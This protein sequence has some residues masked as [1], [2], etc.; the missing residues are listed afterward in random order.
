[1]KDSTLVKFGISGLMAAGAEYGLFA[2]L[3]HSNMRLL[4]ANVLSFAAGV[5]VSFTL[6]RNWSFKSGD[7]Y[8]KKMNRQFMFYLV[9]ALVNVIISSLIVEGLVTTG[10]LPL[11]AKIF[12]MAV[13]ASY[14]FV[15]F[16]FRI[17][18]Q[19]VTQP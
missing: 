13:I 15:I 17:F 8:A 18:N 16:K 14:D 4:I 6:N 10:V 12:S 3:L 5:I 19:T 9:L 2:L 7:P 1:M 11:I